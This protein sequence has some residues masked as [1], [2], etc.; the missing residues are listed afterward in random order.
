[1]RN[2]SFILLVLFLIS[3]ND[4]IVIDDY[5]SFDENWPKDS[6]ATFA[7]NQKDISS[8]HTIYIKIRNTQ[9]YPYN[10]LFLIVSYENPTDKVKVDTLEYAMTN[11][12][13]ELLGGGFSS[14]KE[15]ILIYKEN[16]QFEQKG[17]HKIQIKHALRD[18]GKI[19]GKN[20]LEGILDVGIQIEKNK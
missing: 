6:V 17:E 5:K 11:E 12:K 16:F 8:K 1:M 20:N 4:K 10:N 14:V 9:D 13:G 18:L 15:S 7:F 2:L 3:C 19:E